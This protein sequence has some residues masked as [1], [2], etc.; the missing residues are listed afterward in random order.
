MTKTYSFVKPYYDLESIYAQEGIDYRKQS[1]AVL[2][3]SK[4]RRLE[5]EKYYQQNG[6]SKIPLITHQVYFSFPDNYKK[7]DNLSLSKALIT[8]KRL[9]DAENFKHYIWTN[10]YEAIPEELSF[11]DNVEVHSIYELKD[12]KSFNLVESII[13]QDELKITD[14]V[15][16]SDITRVIVMR[17]FGGIYHDLDYEIYNPQDLLPM[18]KAFN[19]I[20]GEE[21]SN[22][23]K[24][25]GHA[26][27]AATP[28]HPILYKEAELLERNL[29]KDD[30]LMKPDYI[31]YPYSIFDK[32]MFTIGPAVIS[33]AFFQE[34]NKGDNIDILLPHYFLFNAQYLWQNTPESPCHKKTN[35]IVSLVNNYEGESI[36]TIGADSFCGDWHKNDNSHEPIIY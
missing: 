6:E 19:F 4:T 35:K 5:I 34:Q 29:A 27:F 16:A 33:M 9:N 21:S 12:F 25:I 17:E 10:N 31:K 23:Y 26:F 2:T 28:H 15:T 7:I 11:L 13:N 18:L 22:K 1:N 20:A 24:F 32:L 30:G 14:L 3:Q 8:T 36:R